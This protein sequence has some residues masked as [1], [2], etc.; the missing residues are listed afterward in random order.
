MKQLATAHF[1][2][3]VSPYSTNRHDPQ[4]EQMA[5]IAFRFRQMIDGTTDYWVAD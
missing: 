5:D 2:P 3:T 1:T 4:V